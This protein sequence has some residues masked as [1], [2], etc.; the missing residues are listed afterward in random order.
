MNLLQVQASETHPDRSRPIQEIATICRFGLSKEEPTQEF[1]C[2]QRRQRHQGSHSIGPLPSRF[3]YYI[4]LRVAIQAAKTRSLSE[5]DR[6]DDQAARP[7]VARALTELMQASHLSCPL[8]A[9]QGSITH[10]APRRP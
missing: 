1:L 2:E 6:L 7:L 4:G 5:L 3:G 10:L 9:R 8:P